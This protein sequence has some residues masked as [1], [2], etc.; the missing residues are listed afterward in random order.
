MRNSSIFS[1]RPGLAETFMRRP[2]WSRGY[3]AAPPLEVFRTN[4]KWI[5]E[6]NCPVGCPRSNCFA[7]AFHYD[8]LPLVRVHRSRWRLGFHTFRHGC[9]LCADVI[10]MTVILSVSLYIYDTDLLPVAFKITTPK[11]TKAITL[12]SSR[13]TMS[14]TQ[15]PLKVVVAGAGLVGLSVAAILRRQG[16]RVEVVYLFFPLLHFTLRAFILMTSLPF[17]KCI[18]IRI[19]HIPPRNW[20]RDWFRIEYDQDSEDDDTGFEVGEFKRS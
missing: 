1:T 6:R 4:I 3:F 18:D 13:G 11:S 7:H 10:K 15:T 19:L 12:R 2:R 17:T 5:P 20:R 9:I 16:H 8:L 14:S